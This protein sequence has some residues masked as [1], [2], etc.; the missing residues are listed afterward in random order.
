MKQVM[1]KH[2][3]RKTNENI[4]LGGEQLSFKYAGEFSL[5]YFTLSVGGYVEIFV[6]RR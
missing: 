5:W 2:S 1:K 4:W 6:F 3:I